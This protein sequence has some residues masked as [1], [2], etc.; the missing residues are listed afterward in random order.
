MAYGQNPLRRLYWPANV[1]SDPTSPLGEQ[2]EMGEVYGLN[3][4]FLVKFSDPFDHFITAWELELLTLSVQ[5]QTFKGLLIHAVTM[6]FYL[7]H[8]FRST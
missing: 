2:P 4:P 7:D 1:K 3:S 5:S 8:K 6:Y